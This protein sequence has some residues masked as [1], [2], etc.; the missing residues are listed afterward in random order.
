MLRLKDLIAQEYIKDPDLLKYILVQGDKVHF[1]I[2]FAH[3]FLMIPQEDITKIYARVLP[4]IAEYLQKKG[5]RMQKIFIS[6]VFETNEQM[7][8]YFP[9][10]ESRVL[11]LALIRK[12]E[13]TD[14]TKIIR[15]ARMLVD[16]VPG[17]ENDLKALINSLGSGRNYYK[18]L[19]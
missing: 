13:E 12:Y 4:Q 9:Y 6:D 5:D 11:I 14:I 18:W 16:R 1:P 15:H 7:I 2:N 8:Q 19:K 17:L 3:K 10:D